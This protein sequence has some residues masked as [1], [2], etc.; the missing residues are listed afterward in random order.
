M[1]SIGLMF[2]ISFV[3]VFAK[4]WQHQNVNAKNYM[5]AYMT[6]NI[7]T[8]INVAVVGA[9][10]TEGWASA[11]P[12]GISGGVGVVTLMYMYDKITLKARWKAAFDRCRSKA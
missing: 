2:L 4:T 8:F 9:I 6:S 12:L 5:G 1:I 11:L 7:Q 10:V 3:S